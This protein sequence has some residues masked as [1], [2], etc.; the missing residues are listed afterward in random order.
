MVNKKAIPKIIK[1]VGDFVRDESGIV[2]KKN[3]LKTGAL[4][5]SAIIAANIVHGGHD[6]RHTN[7]FYV[8]Y[9]VEESR[10]T[11]EHNHGSETIPST[12][13]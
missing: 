2:S 8:D 10:V 7:S 4:L 1:T 12:E 5:G 11:A 13:H 9:D 6:S 3:I